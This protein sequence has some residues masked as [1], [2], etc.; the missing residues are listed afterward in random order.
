MRI[1]IT[2]GRGFIGRYVTDECVKRG[3]HVVS[4]DRSEPGDNELPDNVAAFLGDVRDPT[5]MTEL[6]AHV[7]G[8][9]HLAACLGT[10]ETILNPRP[11]T[12]TNV[13]GGINFLEACVQYD[14]P[15]VYIAVG[16]Y[17][18][19]NPYSITKTSVERFADMYNHDRHA[20]INVVRVVNAY[21]PRQSI[22]PPFGSA[23]V[24][25]ITPSF[26]CRALLGHDVEIYGDGTQISDMVYVADV[27]NAL[28]TAL[29]RADAGTVFEVPVEVGPAEHATVR[30]VADLVIDTARLLGH[31]ADRPSSKVV[32]LPMR[33]GEQPGAVVS[34]DV[35]TLTMV[36]MR[37]EAL[38][39][40]QQGMDAT[41]AWYASQWLPGH[42]AGGPR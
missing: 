30:Q 22:A 7:D 23:K 16:N 1:G 26:A 42:L 21:G 36:G 6:A 2:G 14:I 18:M 5:A 37:P 41:V 13:A 3:H 12:D 29:E 39:P 34:A 9:I 19:N 17:W 8:I 24:R 32:H 20:R 27:A 33:P 15:G 28:V 38:T 11:A 40:L 10:Q 4:F 31:P 35:S 25:K